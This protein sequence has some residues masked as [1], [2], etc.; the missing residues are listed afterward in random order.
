[1]KSFVMIA[2]MG[3]AMAL[4][5]SAKDVSVKLNGVHL[6][7]QSCVKGAQTAVDKVAGV[8]LTASQDE[9]TVSLSGPDKATVQKAVDSLVEA[10][11]YGKSTDSGIKVK[12][13][14]GATGA[15][16][17]SLEIEG[18]HLC[19]G[20]C[21]KAVNEALGKVGGVTGNTATKGAKK[22]TVTGDFRDTDVFTALQKTGL[23][24]QIAK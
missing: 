15:K 23:T 14:T 19:C 1:M 13:S 9:D 16:V 10:G 17:Q 11:Y 12:A 6:C 7:C 18:V 5:A 4:P 21:V 20:K 3:L 8:T 2:A 24:G 22:F